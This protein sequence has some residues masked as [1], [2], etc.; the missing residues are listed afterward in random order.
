M[1][2]FPFAGRRGTQVVESCGLDGLPLAIELA[3]ARLDVESIDELARDIGSDSLLNRLVS[4]KPAP[5]YAGSVVASLSRSYDLL[6]PAEQ[7]LFHSVSVFSSAFTREM[8]AYVH[9]E[10]DKERTTTF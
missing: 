8:A 7:H 6:S 1:E 10:P 3:A 5:G 9:G 4:P 2:H